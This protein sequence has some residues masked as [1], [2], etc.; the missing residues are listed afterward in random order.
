[1]TRS[2]WP[3]RL[4]AIAAL[5]VLA[6][7]AHLARTRLGLPTT[8]EGLRETVAALGWW[9]PAG[10]LAVMTLRQFLALPSALL[11]TAAGICFDLP[12]ATAL[13]ATG[14]M[15]SAVLSFALARGV[16]RDWV[17]GRE[18]SRAR[19]LGAVIERV[20][21]TVIALS[22]A[23]PLGLLTP[24]HWAAGLSRL[25]PRRFV[26]ALALGAPVRAFAYALFGAALLDTASATFRTA[27]IALAAGTLLV[28][29]VGPIRHRIFGQV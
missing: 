10:L 7:G 9:G 24:L 2:R 22:T 29:A 17:A 26:W 4:L 18:G 16:L 13:G 8:I 27:S 25:R 28:L 23:H 11:L 20:G 14:L 1:M 3:R 21:P 15:L 12:T 5:V 19:R 6:A